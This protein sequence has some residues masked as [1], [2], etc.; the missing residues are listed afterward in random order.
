MC[1][2]SVILLAQPS[3]PGTM[4]W[5]FQQYMCIFALVKYKSNIGRMSD[6]VPKMIS[7]LLKFTFVSLLI[8][9]QALT[10]VQKG[11]TFYVYIL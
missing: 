6:S 7:V 4:F 9:M 2:M 10:L 3:M 5:N 11:T 1:F 8:E